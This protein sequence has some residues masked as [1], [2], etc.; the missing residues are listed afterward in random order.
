[1]SIS[2]AILGECMLELS[3]EESS[4][5]NDNNLR[6]L[7]FG[8]DTLN[9]A[10]YLSR[11]DIDVSYVSA[12]GLDSNSNWLIKNWEREGIVCSL[13]KRTPGLLPGLYMIDIDDEGER[14]FMYWRSSSAA[15]EFFNNKTS[16]EEALLELINFN[17]IYLSGI[18][19]AIMNKETR[20]VLFRLLANYKNKGGKVIFDSNYR[21]ALW[22]D[23]ETAQAAYTE[24]YR[25]T[26]IA[27]PTFE[28]EKELFSFQS[29][30]ETV[31][32]LTKLGV[33]E[34][35]IKLGEEGCMFFTNHE[36]VY[37][38]SN[39]VDVV[40]TTAAGDSF[41]AAYLASRFSGLNQ[42]EA[43]KAGHFLAARVVQTKGAILPKS[44]LSSLS[45]NSNES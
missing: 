8:G 19:L 42:D 36:F 5:G 16:I 21:P 26:N 7:S 45:A 25:L 15:R 31:I 32:S 17:Y 24:M 13:V 35:V 1:M 44:N 10:I 40:D 39:L 14:S 4:I 11:H 23:E 33:E 28:D 41:N 9:T 43:C 20:S 18:T 29:E 12:L 30:K 3:N 6:K 22:P 37:I 34:V 38:K 2:V 27:L